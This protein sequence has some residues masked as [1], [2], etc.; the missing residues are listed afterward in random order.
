MGGNCTNHT[1]GNWYL[2]KAEE[3][4]PKK[5]KKIKKQI[6]LYYTP[7]VSLMFSKDMTAPDLISFEAWEWD[8]RI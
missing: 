7:A 1:P 5:K 3:M 8:T 4:N 6:I 2:L